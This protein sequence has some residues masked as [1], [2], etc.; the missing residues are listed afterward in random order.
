MP[1]IMD[2]YEREFANLKPRLMKWVKLALCGKKVSVQGAENFPEQGPAIIVGNH[3]GSF[4][5]I[6]VL[7]LIA[8]RQ[9]HFTANKQ[10]F[11][12]DEFNVLIRYHLKLHLKELGGLVDVAIRPIKNPFVKFISGNIKAVGSIPVDLLKGK[13]HALRMCEKF[14]KDG[15]AVVLLQGR[16]RINPKDSHPFMSEFKRGPAILCYSLYHNHGLEV[17]VIPVAM[18]GTHALWGVPSKIKVGVGKPLKITEFPADD[19]SVS[20]S[21]FRAAMEK[22]TRVLLYR[23]I[24]G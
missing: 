21:R 14:L 12:R 15:R 13:T 22:R 17:P 1:L 8:P 3:I 2:V 23:L 9:I 24:K 16:G 19:F 6:S 20:I 10:I 4:K 18:Y 5:D 11:D 7:F